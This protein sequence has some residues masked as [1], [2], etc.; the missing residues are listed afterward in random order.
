[1]ARALLPGSRLNEISGS[2]KRYPGFQVLVW[3]PDFVSINEVA[4]GTVQ[5]APLDITDWVLSVRYQENI[6]FENGDD[7]TF[8]S[9]TIT[10]RRVPGRIFREGW[11]ADRVIVRVLQGDLRVKRDEWLPIFTGTFRGRAGNNPGTRADLSEGLEATAYGREERYLNLQVTTEKFP[12][13]TDV[14]EIAFEIAR[15]HMDLGQDEILFGAQGY[16]S[17]HVS[18]QIVELPALEALYQCL[19]PV[20][21][22]PK[23]DSTGRLVAVDV[24]LDKPAARIFSAGDLTI[25]S[26]VASPNDVEVANHVILRGLDHTLSKVIQEAQLLVELD[27][28]TGFFD[29]E[30]ERRVFYSQDHSQRAQDTYVVEKKRIRWSDSTW[31]EKDEFS[32]VLEIDT[33]YLRNVRAIIF[34]AWLAT[35]IFVAIID[36]FFQGEGAASIITT[37]FGINVTL[38]TLRFILQMASIVTLALLLWAMNFIGRGHYQVWGKRFEFVYQEL[39][40]DARLVGLLPEELRLVEYRNDFLSTMEVLDARAKDL[41]RREL[42]KN[43]L[44]EITLVDDLLLEV[45]D[46]IEDQAGSRYYILSVDKEL[47]R[48]AAPLMTLTTWKVWDAETAAIEAAATGAEA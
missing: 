33:R 27:V 45:D 13:N 12:Q 22:K 21:K 26:K 28:T 36:L 24:N 11:I 48:G 43:Q 18:N 42:V 39:V 41:L 47:R 2:L 4:A 5:E 40:S 17:Q 29:S 46:I 23:F 19:F 31:T 14:G 38:A 8:P 1:M 9:V 6:G 15:T 7:P 20:G 3:D 44:H 34:V 10:F 16:R 35:Q 32:G 25:A 37:I 30:F